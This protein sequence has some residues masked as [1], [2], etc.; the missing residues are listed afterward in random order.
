VRRV[1]VAT[2]GLAAGA[3]ITAACSSS[4]SSGPSSPASTASGTPTTAA[5]FS[6]QVTQQLQTVVS[7]AEQ[8]YQIPG[9]VAAVSVPGQGS[10]VT[11]SGQASLSP[12]ERVT[13]SSLFW[14]GSI[15][16]TF[17]GTVILQLVQQGKLSLTSPISQWAPNVQNASSITVQ[18]L[19]N[20]TS[21]IFDEGGP[22]SQVAANPSATYTPQQIVDLAVAHGP[23]QPPG[24]FYYSDTNYVL[25]GIIAQDVSGQPIQNLISNQI[26]GPLHLTHTSY[27]TAT[28]TGPFAPV[29]NGYVVGQGQPMPGP[30]I[31]PTALGAAGAMIST[32]GDLQV[33]AKA[34]ATGSLLSSATQQ[35]RLQ[36]VPTG[37]IFP[38]LP[39]TGVSTGLPVQY[40]LGIS[41]WGGLL[42]HNGQANAYNSDMLYLPAK[43]ATV[44]VLANGY[45]PSFAA[46][47]GENVSDAAAV[48]M[49]QIVLP[50][51]LQTTAVPTAPSRAVH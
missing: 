3:L 51:A 34:L 18:M 2:V 50:G 17:T 24:Q 48:S 39:G 35:Q 46:T 16:K 32:V 22:G 6:P 4:T 13:T 12:G 9:I 1:L 21:G 26:L 5:S 30:T 37:I 7:L 41:S 8:Q 20:M 49:A 25:L 10:W 19:L 44:I 33:W 45:N 40:G 43:S 42:G 14:I 27:P 47:K 31:N 28:P 38:P 29:G 11:A 36:F 15:T 23:A